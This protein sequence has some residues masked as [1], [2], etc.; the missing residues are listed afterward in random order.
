MHNFFKIYYFIE[1]FNRAEIQKLDK[2][3]SLIYRNYKDKLD[4]KLIKKTKNYCNFQKRS[5][6][7]SNNLKIAKNLKL[8]GI[9]IPSFNKLANFKNINTK[10]NFKILGSAHNKAELINKE[11]QGCKEIFIAPLFKT[12]KQNFYLDIAKFNLTAGLSKKNIIALGGINSSNLYK[13][14][15]VRCNGFASIS[16]IKKNR[17]NKLGRF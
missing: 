9:Y 17:P 1:D 4:I 11:N 13:L 15:S 16:W 7:I 8:D 14:R 3:I 2:N 6:F 5:F 12:T 10:K